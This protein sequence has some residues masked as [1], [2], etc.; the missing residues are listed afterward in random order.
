MLGVAELSKAINIPAFQTNS[1][2]CLSKAK[3]YG[4]KVNI[5]VEDKSNPKLPE[6]LGV[7]N[8]YTELIPCRKKVVVA[9][10][11]TSARNLTIPEG[12]VEGNIFC[13]N[14]I[15]KILTQSI[16]VLEKDI[17][18]FSSSTYPEEKLIDEG[19]WVL[20]KVDLSGMQSLSDECCVR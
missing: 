7:Q 3:K 10:R 2:H 1:V 17:G 18:N 5:M 19:K 6:G 20:G 13:A 8:T 9:V 14:K 16:R 12:R 11:N 15:P 4:M